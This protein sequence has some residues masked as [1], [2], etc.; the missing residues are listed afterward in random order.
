MQDMVDIAIIGAGPYGLSL[1]AHLR[2]R[3][4]E[5]RVFG[6][7]MSL[8]RTR[9]PKGMRLKSEGFASNLYDPDGTFTLECYCAENNIPYADVG[10]PVTLEAFT[11]YGLAFQSRFVP[12]VENRV[13]TELHRHDRGF[14]L[15]FKDGGV[16]GARRVIVAIGVSDFA[17]LPSVLTG[18]PSALVSHSSGHHAL[19]KF[20]ARDVAV[21]GA[22]ASAVDVASLLRAVGA[23]P[24]L[25]ARAPRLAF[26]HPPGDPDGKRPLMQRLRWPLTGIG[27]GWKSY[28]CATMPLAFRRLPVP[29]R[30]QLVRTHLGPAPGW[31]TKNEVVGKVA[32]RLGRSLEQVE[33]ESGRVRLHLRDSDRL[34]EELLVDHVIAATGYRA[35]LRR[36]LFIPES[37]RK[38][39]ALAGDAPALSE[40]CESSIAGLYFVGPISANTFGP[41]S[42]FAFGAGFAAHRLLRHFA[43]RQTNIHTAD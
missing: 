19:D 10:L 37:L 21:V 24:V 1:A 27:N 2:A 22:G 40:N 17:Y 39:I 4:Y 12:N 34:K 43:A 41:L 29:I 35:N 5:V 31:F 42:R 30:L 32:M 11:R 14:A 18:F 38:D 8:W 26:H 28:L 15:H 33:Q 13:V 23:N 7:A 25:I 3:R 9:M 20:A 36:L 6:D 16:V